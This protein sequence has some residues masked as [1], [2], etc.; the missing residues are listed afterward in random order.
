MK[1]IFKT[2]LFA[3]CAL[4][5]SLPSTAQELIEA[6]G[7]GP[8]IFIS[9]DKNGKEEI[10]NIFKET[11]RPHF[12]DPGAPRFLLTDKKGKWALGIGGYVQAKA[13]YDFGGI[14]D[15]V[16]FYPSLIS[17]GKP[18]NQFQMDITTSTLFLKL[19][20]KTHKLGNFVVYTAGNW[21]GDGKT[22]ELQNAYVQ[23]LGFTLGYDTG[24][25][26]DL[27]AGPPTIDFAGPCGMTFYRSTL[28]RY[29]HAL[30]K[31]FSAGIALEMPD[32]DGTT[33]S[34]T[35]VSHQRLPHIPAFVQYGW[36]K[37]K[38]HF[39]LGGIY[40][41][42]TYTDLVLDKSE[43]QTGWGVQASTTISICKPLQFFGQYTYGKGIGGL[44]N[45]I[46]NLNVDIV[47]NMKEEGKMQVLPMSGWY[48][49]LQYNFT[50]GLFT[51]ATY[52]Q[53]RLYSRHS[54]QQENPEQYKLGQYLVTNV[55]WNIVPNLQLGVEYL[56]GWRKD[57]DRESKKANRVNLSAQFN[58]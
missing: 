2:T 27:A 8:V 58:F 38:S 53:S 29:E 40:R 35:S 19:V 54:Y 23:F 37:G 4:A 21:R 16:D 44:V 48:A 25:F 50:P 9:R 42:I 12:H 22:F 20:G 51:S 41:H 3:W 32:I 33:D 39:R 5:C 43:N 52:S 24:T 36:N 55:F 31:G 11:Q 10:I 7:P 56:H 49:G 6:E 18:R 30:G 17:E 57:F 1:P 34:Y 14:V 13:E 28:I 47:P 26:M 46:S 15:D 45:D